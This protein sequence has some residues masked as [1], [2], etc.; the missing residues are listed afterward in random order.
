MEPA[1]KMDTSVGSGGRSI[2]LRVYILPVFASAAQLYSKCAS[3]PEP[4]QRPTSATGPNSDCHF[5]G[6]FL[7]GSL[8]HALASE[9][10]WF[11]HCLT[12]KWLVSLWPGEA[13][14]Q[15]FSVLK[16]VV[17]ATVSVFYFLGRLNTSQRHT[18]QSVGPL[19][20][21]LDLTLCRPRLL[22]V[23]TFALMMDLPIRHSS[24]FFQH[25]LLF[26][27]K[28]D[29]SAPHTLRNRAVVPPKCQ[30]WWLCSQP[31]L[32]RVVGISIPSICVCLR[33][34]RH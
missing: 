3:L 8:L 2:Y 13:E 6:S 34:H 21:R 20:S 4:T 32:V 14:K 31:T 26:Q 5:W 30:Q 28:F 1:N 25:P 7:L 33:T 24:S 10:G 27:N 9:R 19:P 16:E 17:F 22:L 11:R 15:T 18:K 12:S 23:S 29:L